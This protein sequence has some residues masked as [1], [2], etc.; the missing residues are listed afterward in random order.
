MEAKDILELK[1]LFDSEHIDVWL[2]GGWGVDA[3]LGKQTRPHADVDI[4]IQEKDI[5]KLRALLEARGYKEIK[6]EIARPFNFVMGDDSGHEIDVHAFTYDKDGNGVYGNHGPAFPADCFKGIGEING[7][8]VRCISAEQIVKFHTGYVLDEN[9]FKDITA[10][11]EKFEIELPWEYRLLGL[12]RE[13]HINCFKLCKMVFGRYLPIAGNVG[14]F[15]QSDE[16]YE[17]FLEVREQITEPSDNPKQ[18][19]FKLKHKMVI[20]ATED[21]PETSY[22]YLYIR[23]PSPDS[24][25]LGDVDFILSKEEFQKLKQGLVEGETLPGAKIYKRPGWDMIELADPTINAL[26][27]VTYREMAEKACVRFD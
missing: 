13:I 9:D 11:C 20:P 16:E 1:K 2:D 15:C 17:K 4:I 22:E 8:K 19:Y 10:L 18:K 3:L 7:Q 27:Y 25:Q 24:P 21:L 12:V 6:L 26:P 14:V 5:P 23:R